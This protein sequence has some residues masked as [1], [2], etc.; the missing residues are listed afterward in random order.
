MD[1]VCVTRN[2]A[3]ACWLSRDSSNQCEDTRF[4]DGPVAFWFDTSFSMRFAIPRGLPGTQ[5]SRCNTN[6][7]MLAK[8]LGSLW[9]GPSPMSRIFDAGHCIY[10]HFT[11][12]MCIVCWYLLYLMIFCDDARR[13]IPVNVY[14]ITVLGTR[15]RCLP[16]GVF[17][18]QR[19]AV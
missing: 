15:L 4:D 2:S 14:F 19:K 16:L 17:Q 13:P 11:S 9:Y 3:D 1:T 7:F 5:V 10:F 12:N 18:N 6:D 8:V